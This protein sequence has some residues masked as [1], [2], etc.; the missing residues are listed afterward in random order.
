MAGAGV[1]GG[2]DERATICLRCLGSDPAHAVW[3]GWRGDC[4]YLLGVGSCSYGDCAS[5]SIAE[6]Q[7]LTCNPG[8]P[9]GVPETGWGPAPV[10][11]GEPCWGCGGLGA[12]SGIVSI[13]TGRRV[14]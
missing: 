11:R 10:P 12:V 5:P 8:L 2:R 1:R 4:D 14:G 9:G 13:V 3:D 6:P 7:C